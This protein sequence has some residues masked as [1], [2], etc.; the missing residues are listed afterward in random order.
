M[1]ALNPILYGLLPDHRHGHEQRGRRAVRMK[2]FGVMMVRNEA[3]ILRVNFLHHLDQGV[4]YF[5]VV[6]NG[7]WDGTGG[8]LQELSR[9]G[10]LGWIR[11]PGPYQQ[12][13]ITTELA[14]EAFRSGADWVVPI[15]ADEF[16]WAPGGDFRGVLE[17]SEAGALEVE[18]VNFIQRRSQTKASPDA[19]LHMTR[20]APDPAGPLG[21]A[22]ELFESGKHAFVE[23]MMYPKWISRATAFTE[24]EM[25]DHGVKGVPQPREKTGEIICLH[26]PLRAR[27]T[28]FSKAVDQGARVRELDLTPGDW[29]QARRWY[30]LAML[31]D[32]DREWRANSYSGGRLDVYGASHKV[33]F[34]PRLRDVVKPWIRTPAPAVRE[35]PEAAADA[36]EDDGAKRGDSG[37]GSLEAPAKADAPGAQK[38]TA[39]APEARV[40]PA[41][42]EE[43]SA[44]AATLTSSEASIVQLVGSGKR[45]LIVGHSVP[46]LARAMHDR[47]CKVVAVETDLS[48]ALGAREYVEHV[49][50]GDIERL[51]LFQEL[52]EPGFDCVVLAGL[53]E[54]VREPLV[55]LRTLKKYIRSD[56][57]LVSAVP[58][59]AHAAS[60]IKLLREGRL[61]RMEN[62]RA[63]PRSLHSYTRETLE[64]LLEEA[65]FAL[66]R[67]DRCELLV[68]RSDVSQG[69]PAVPAK[70]LEDLSQD[71][72]ARTT[73]FV[74]LAYPLPHADLNLI[75]ER[76]REM[77]EQNDAAR[78]ELAALRPLP[79][80]VAKLEGQGGLFRDLLKNERSHGEAALQELA[81]VSAKVETLLK[82][83]RR[84]G[85]DAARLEKQ[86]QDAAKALVEMFGESSQALEELQSRDKSLS[87]AVRRSQSRVRSLEAELQETLN[88]LDGLCRVNDSLTEAL[89]RTE[90]DRAALQD[91]TQR[92]SEE[93]EAIRRNLE[94]VASSPGWK[95]ISFYRDWLQRSIWTK[96]WLR[97]PYEAVAQRMLGLGARSSV[98]VG[99]MADSASSAGVR[100]SEG[101]SRLHHLDNRFPPAGFGMGKNAK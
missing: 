61:P 96:P 48:A 62:D 70:L 51:R 98:V 72:D 36:K 69:D 91:R 38:T 27:S 29:W 97:K 30:E 41:T 89:G 75:Q 74:A 65:G 8:V 78:R 20:R 25:G 22:Q 47:N 1:E 2:I 93:R 52:N 42:S 54:S 3:D 77:A 35:E 80:R 64:Q 53:L 14:R 28:W 49:V 11:D 44:L 12:S 73:H 63:A 50:V 79:T 19:L 87:K 86:Q 57:S 24:I 60:R 16:W 66:G 7:S 33:V 9:S 4:D 81:E 88:R 101:A 5:L 31:G 83:N 92:L 68:E 100:E 82:A 37:D 59:V 67:L 99:G 56:G 10:R 45:V 94:A 34:D 40:N 90:N 39:T 55:V 43:Q 21:Q 13:E 58:N 26:A 95:L 71:A 23:L 84:L 6:D 46:S 85:G 15:D 32:L 18:V 76:M 17:E